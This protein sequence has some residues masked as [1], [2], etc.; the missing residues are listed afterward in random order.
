MRPALVDQLSI[1]DE[2][3]FSKDSANFI[4]V[5]YLKKAPA[6]DVDSDEE[7]EFSDDEEERRHKKGL[8]T[9]EVKF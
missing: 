2:I 3:R 6:A 9:G 7:V 8:E 4:N 5:E 1:G